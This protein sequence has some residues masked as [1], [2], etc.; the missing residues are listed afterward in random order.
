SQNRPMMWKTMSQGPTVRSPLQ[1]P[2][3]IAPHIKKRSWAWWHMPIIPET[4]EAKA[5]GSQ[6]G[7]QLCQLNKTLPQNKR[8]GDVAQ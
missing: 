3:G 8:A 2:A 1:E 7:S 6:V 5:G 4:Q